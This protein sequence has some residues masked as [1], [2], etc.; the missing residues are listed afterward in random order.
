MRTLITIFMVSFLVAG[1]VV[2]PAL[3]GEK[4]PDHQEF[5]ETLVSFYNAEKSKDWKTYWSYFNKVTQEEMPYDTFAEY[6]SD[7]GQIYSYKV[8]EIKNYGSDI[9]TP[10]KN[11]RTSRSYNRNDYQ[12]RTC[13]IRN[14][15]SN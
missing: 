11:Y 6:M 13:S 9:D 4:L 2:L 3:N 15:S 5:K 14:Q 1:C 10:E 7:T 12:R 8:I